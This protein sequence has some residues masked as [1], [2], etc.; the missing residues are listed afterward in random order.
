MARYPSELTNVAHEVV[1][2][3]PPE[4][5]LS[6]PDFFLA[7]LMTYGTIEEIAVSRNFFTH[8]QFVHALENAPPGV[9]DARSWTYWNTVLGRLPVPPMPRR[10]FLQ[11]A[12][13][14][15]DR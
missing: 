8:E 4:Q 7:H 12:E 15:A 2:F 13:L 3:L 9:F 1:W 11:D 10:R 6:D 5:A 14:N